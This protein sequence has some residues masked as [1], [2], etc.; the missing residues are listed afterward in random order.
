LADIEQLELSIVRHQAGWGRSRLGRPFTL[1][2]THLGNGWLYLALALALPWLVPDALFRAAI[3]AGIGAGAAHGAYPTLKRY[4][5]R[6]RPCDRQ[7]VPLLRVLDLHSF[8]SGHAMT[9]VAVAVPLVA[10]RPAL[11]VPALICCASIAWSRLLAAHH[12]PSDVLAGAGLGVL[13]SLPPTL[14]LL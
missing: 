1:V 3:A 12:Y 6:A 4:F 5:A 8:P 14:V 13:A 2:F 9:A 7:I 10:A 11:A